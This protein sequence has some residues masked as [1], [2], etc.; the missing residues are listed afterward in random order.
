MLICMGTIMTG[1]GIDQ[2]SSASSVLVEYATIAHAIHATTPNMT[3]SIYTMSVR[4]P[5][6]S[7]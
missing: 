7:G 6:A 2:I 5:S 3:V 4:S 1:I